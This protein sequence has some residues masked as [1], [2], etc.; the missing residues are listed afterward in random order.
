MKLEVYT[1]GGCTHNGKQNAQASYGY[2]FP[3]HK[4]LSFASRVPADQPQT[5]NRGELLGIL[6]AI[7][8]A[9]A[10]FPAADVNLHV[11]TDSEYS[12]NCITKWLPGW[13]AKGWKTSSGTAVLNRD[14]IEDIS[15]RLL[16]F[17]SHTF[18]YVRAHTGGDDEMSKNNH[19][20][21]RMVSNILNP[22]E[23]VPVAKVDVKGPLQMMGPPVSETQLYNW[24]I[25]NLK[26]LDPVIL[27]TS[28]ISAYTKSMKKNGYEVTKQKLHRTNEYRLIA[29]NHLTTTHTD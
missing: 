23:A 10:S 27:R 14:L 15:G 9:Q 3:E 5:N 12:K 19:I 26:E 4:E 24:C 13:I 17:E 21:D 29:G 22:E 18:T 2:Y 6:E 8:K 7:K 16:C 25:A 1:D 28:I 20:V 11:F